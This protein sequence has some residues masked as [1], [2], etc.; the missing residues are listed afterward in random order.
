MAQSFFSFLHA[1]VY[2]G[3]Q[4]RGGRP[5]QCIGPEAPAPLPQA[6]RQ[7]AVCGSRARGLPVQIAV[8]PQQSALKI[9]ASN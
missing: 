5:G 7:Q 9:E 1:R 4:W 6:V 8:L 2:S 3:V